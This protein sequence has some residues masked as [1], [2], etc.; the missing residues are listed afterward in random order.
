MSNNFRKKGNIGIVENRIA[1]SCSEKLIKDMGT[2][3]FFL[4]FAF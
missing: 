4:G 2:G 3:F 1:L